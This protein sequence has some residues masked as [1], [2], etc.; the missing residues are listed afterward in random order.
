[1]NAIND[2]IVVRACDQFHGYVE[3]DISKNGYYIRPV[4]NHYIPF[5][6]SLMTRDAFYT[7]DDARNSGI[8]WVA[9]LDRVAKLTDNEWAIEQMDKVVDHWAYMK[10]IPNETKLK[11]REYLLGLGEPID[12]EIRFCNGGI[13]WRKFKNKR[14]NPVPESILG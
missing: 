10:S 3:A 2:G 8:E 11:V 7:Y 14:W 6:I 5:T 9:E 13:E 1:M 4:Y 12:Y